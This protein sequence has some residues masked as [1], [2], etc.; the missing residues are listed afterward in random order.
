M[1][2]RLALAFSAVVLAGTATAAEAATVLSLDATSACGKG[3]CFDNAST[4]FQKAF[5]GPL[6]IS[7]LKIDKAMLGEFADYA[8]KISFTTKDGQ[9]VGNWGAYTLAVLAGDT[10]TIGGQAVEWSGATGDLILT[11]EVLVPKKGGAGGGG[12]G[13]ASAPSELGFDRGG[14]S[15]GIVVGGGPLPTVSGAPATLPVP[16]RGPFATAVPEPGA[17]ALMLGGFFG[18]GLALRRR[19]QGAVA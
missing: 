9:M 10:V 11:L 15:G 1:N 7:G 3:G 5:S 4:T 18:S 19:R 12:G 8:V 17:W 13:F 16:G 2:K 6:S 14:T